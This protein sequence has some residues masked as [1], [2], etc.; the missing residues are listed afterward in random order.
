MKTKAVSTVKP[1]QVTKGK[2]QTHAW[3]DR[4]AISAYPFAPAPF[5]LAPASIFIYT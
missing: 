2:D 5:T 3:M 1:Q 4:A